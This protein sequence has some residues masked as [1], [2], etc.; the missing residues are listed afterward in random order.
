MNTWSALTQVSRAWVETNLGDL[1][2]AVL[3]WTAVVDSVYR[4]KEPVRIL[5]LGLA[6][7]SVS[8]HLLGQGDAVLRA[9]LGPEEAR[10]ALPEFQA[11]AGQ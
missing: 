8:Q 9:A 5:P 1:P 4:A 11:K 2:S 10:R 7:L 3:R 6:G